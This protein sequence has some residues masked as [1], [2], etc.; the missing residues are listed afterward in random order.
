MLARRLPPPEERKRFRLYGEDE[1]LGQNRAAI[2]ISPFGEDKK[3]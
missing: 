1:R 2:I 3:I